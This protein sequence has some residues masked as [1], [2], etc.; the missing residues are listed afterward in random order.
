MK[1]AVTHCGNERK[2]GIYLDWLK[3]VEP[4]A[5]CTTI[6]SDIVIAEPGDF[7][8][9]VLTGGDDVAAEFSKAAPSDL[10]QQPDT[11]RDRFEF[12]LIDKALAHNIPLFG[13]CRGMQVINVRLGGTL[14]ADL[15]H[16]GFGNH[17][18]KSGQEEVRHTIRVESGTLL[19]K[20]AGRSNGEVNSYHHQAVKDLAGTLTASSYSGDGVIESVEWKVGAGRPFLLAVQWHPER[21]SDRE[22]PFTGKIAAAFFDAVKKFSLS[23]YHHTQ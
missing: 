16:D 10:V 1:I 15:R 22:N 13:I 17:E 23:T 18:T 9:I 4:A 11:Q 19:E 8:G 12:Q 20:I 7:D 14:I 6:S 2:Q 21:M 5:D 3:S